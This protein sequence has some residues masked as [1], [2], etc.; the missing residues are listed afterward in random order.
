MKLRIRGNSIRFRL[1]ESEV[2]QLAKAGRVSD[3]VQFSALPRN[4]LTYSVEASPGDR[5]IGARYQ[6][7]EIM[8]TIPSAAVKE[9]ADSEQVGLNGR[10][11]I[12]GELGLAISI[13][14][15]FRCLATRP[16]EDESDSFANPADG[17][18]CDAH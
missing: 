16:G 9:W 18:S 2:A 3:S 8:V 7:N 1:G 12:S 14:K 10:Q 17:R 5:E 6:G 11:A 15:D 13:E 4:S